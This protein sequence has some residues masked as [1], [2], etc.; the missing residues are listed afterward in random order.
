MSSAVKAQSLLD[1]A[2]GD[3]AA[4]KA[5]PAADRGKLLVNELHL[6]AQGTEWE[7]A[8]SGVEQTSSD[9]VL[10]E[11]DGDVSGPLATRSVVWA[12]LRPRPSPEG[13]FVFVLGAQ[14]SG[15]HHEDQF[16]AGQLAEERR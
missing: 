13:P 6:R 12:R 15:G 7:V 11:G 9:I 16:F 3:A 10:S 8:E 4:V 2:Y 5:L 1:M 14:L